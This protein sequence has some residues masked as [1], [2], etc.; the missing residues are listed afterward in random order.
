M[1]KLR[2]FQLHAPTQGREVNV[3]LSVVSEL[4]VHWLRS[5][6]AIAAPFRKL[7]V[8]VRE[9]EPLQGPDWI[10]WPGGV[11]ELRIWCPELGDVAG[12]TS[13][14]TFII[15]VVRKALAS[16][17]GAGADP[18]LAPGTWAVL[19]DL[20]TA[21]EP[22]V[23][24]LER[25][26]CRDAGSHRRYRTL[27]RFSTAR[28]EIVLTSADLGEFAV[29]HSLDMFVPLDLFFPASRCVAGGGMIEYVAANGSRIT[30]VPSPAR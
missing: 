22:H 27:Y 2:D 7:L 26:S 9:E 13:T 1:T 15:D 5:L 20:L 23:L 3:P 4:V 30:A 16:S 10:A 24:E 12:A 18:F 25:L 21:D 19:R 11:A 29:I 28:S 8:T 6:P 17:E 14:P